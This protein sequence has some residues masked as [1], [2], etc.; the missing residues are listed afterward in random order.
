M[1]KHKKGHERIMLQNLQERLERKK[2]LTHCLGV[3]VLNNV[4]HKITE[5]VFEKHKADV[6]Y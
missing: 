2:L 4:E 6:C 1:E 5:H 3:I